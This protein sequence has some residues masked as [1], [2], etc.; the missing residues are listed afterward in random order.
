[1]SRPAS[2][3][4]TSLYRPLSR[5][6]FRQLRA[7][8]EV[9]DRAN[10]SRAAEPLGIAQP[11]LSQQILRVERG[12]GVGPVPPASPRRVGP[13]AGM[14][15]AEAREPPCATFDEEIDRAARCAQ[16]EAGQFTVGSMTGAALAQHSAV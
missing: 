12:L 13:P 1:V 16:G 5:R 10:F 8:V 2:E 3:P 6:T 9:A 7:E 11:A 4:P 15:F 14:M